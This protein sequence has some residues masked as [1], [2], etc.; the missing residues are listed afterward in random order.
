[1]TTPG[2]TAPPIRLLTSP[3]TQHLSIR[4]ISP[5][6]AATSHPR[7]SHRSLGCLSSE[8]S[9]TSAPSPSRGS[10]VLAGSCSPA[11]PFQLQRPATAVS[12]L[13]PSK[14]PPFA[15]RAL[16]G[17][18]GPESPQLLRRREHTLRHSIV[19]RHL[20]SRRPTLRTHGPPIPLSSIALSQGHRSTSPA[21]RFES[22]PR[23]ATYVR[24]GHGLSAAQLLNRARSHIT[25]ITTS[26]DLTTFVRHTWS[27]C[28]H[29]LQR[30]I[31][32]RTGSP[33]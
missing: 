4:H 17:E 16:A 30:G 8:P 15:S 25:R 27:N 18:F 20:R 28:R 22:S 2:G 3:P 5:F 6:F 7:P 9:I 21:Q 13:P 29:G 26:H 33:L 12:H 11:P 32:R 24:L 23:L 19:A 14:R 31:W 1:M 10:Q